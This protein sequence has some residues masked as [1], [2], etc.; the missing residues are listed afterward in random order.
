MLACTW[1]N[2]N[3][4]ICMYVPVCAECYDYVLLYFVE[5]VFYVKFDIFTVFSAPSKQK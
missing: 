2:A 5:N 1:Y 4:C 3:C